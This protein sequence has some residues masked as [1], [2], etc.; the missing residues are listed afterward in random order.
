MKSFMLLAVSV[1]AMMAMVGCAT[2]AGRQS[3]PTAPQTQVI[4]LPAPAASLSA[5]TVSDRRGQASAIYAEQDDYKRAM[6]EDQSDLRWAREDHRYSQMSQ[7]EVRREQ[8]SV[9]KREIALR[10]QA[11]RERDAVVDRDIDLRRQRQRELDGT[12][13]RWDK[14]VRTGSRVVQTIDR[15][16]H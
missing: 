13:R 7:R 16:G 11:E 8:E 10:R 9:V 4:Y 5:Q 15:L 3:Y 2:T 12:L 6:K 14:A 1:I